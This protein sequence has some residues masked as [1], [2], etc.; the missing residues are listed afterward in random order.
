MSD[1]IPKC[2]Q[3]RYDAGRIVLDVLNLRV[4]VWPGFPAF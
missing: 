2:C 4:I 3:A 1:P